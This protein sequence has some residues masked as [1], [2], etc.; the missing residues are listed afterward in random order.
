MYEFISNNIELATAIVNI[1]GVPTAIFIYIKEQ[2][3][4]REAAEYGTYDALDNKY[5]E[6]QQLCLEYSNLDIFDTPYETPAK[7]N[8][9]EEKQ[10]EAILL[11]RVSIFERAFLMYSRTPKKAKS[12]QWQGWEEDILDWMDRPN[13]SK[14]W[15]EQK[16]YFDSE[17]MKYFDNKHKLSAT[18]NKL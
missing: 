12:A 6:L 2:R 16:E 7:L 13:Y 1:L 5:I 10:E 17:F 11:I 4:Q 18:T 15:L 9:Q 14:V 8:E 3:L